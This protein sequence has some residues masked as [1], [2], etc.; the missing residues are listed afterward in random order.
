MCKL[1]QKLKLLEGAISYDGE[2]STQVVFL[3]A[4]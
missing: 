2:C 3:L 4:N 1:I